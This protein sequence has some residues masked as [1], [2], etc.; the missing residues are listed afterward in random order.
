[1]LLQVTAFGQELAGTLRRASVVDALVRR[2][3]ECLSPSEIA[4][5]LFDPEGEGRDF[6]QHWPSGAHDRRTL[7]EV[8]GRRGPL[9]LPNGL[10]PVLSDGGLDPQPDSDGSWI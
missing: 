4:L 2:I 8:A 9:L 6:S 10:G 7:L 1:M 3:Q 5:A